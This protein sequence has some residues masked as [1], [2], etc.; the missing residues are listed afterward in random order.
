M[1][2]VTDPDLDWLRSLTR[3]VRRVSRAMTANRL[4]AALALTLIAGAA[5]ATVAQ[6]HPIQEISR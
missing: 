1:P 6:S 4:A 2:P 3:A 5:W